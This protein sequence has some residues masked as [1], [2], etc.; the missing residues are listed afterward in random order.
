MKIFA[1]ILGVIFTLSSHAKSFDMKAFAQDYF[2]AM[3][4]TQQPNASEKELEAYLSLLADD[5]GHSHL[6]WMTDDSRQPDGKA[7][8]RKGM[9]YY[10]GAHTSYEAELLDVFVFNHSAI[11]IRYRHRAEGIHPDNNQPLKFD[12][13]MMDILEIEDQKV[14]VIR[15]YHQ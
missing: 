8:F 12:Q 3:V 15:K 11:A 4:A 14:A 5:V 2:E 7:Q 9:T 13:V 10:L 1:I 6:P